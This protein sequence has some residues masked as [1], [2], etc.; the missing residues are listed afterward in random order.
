MVQVI[1]NLDQSNT[2]Q[3]NN[4]NVTKE[5]FGFELNSHTF[6]TPELDLSDLSSAQMYFNLAYALKSNQTD[7]VR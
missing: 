7:F 5:D 6:T 3:V 1:Y 2:H 4:Q